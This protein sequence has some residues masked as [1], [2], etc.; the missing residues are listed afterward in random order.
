MGTEILHD[1]VA[2]ALRDQAFVFEVL[3]IER[4]RRRLLW[5]SPVHHRLGEGRL[6]GFVVAVTAITPHVDNDVL[7]EALPILHRDA[8]DMDA[9]LPDRRR[10]RGRSVPETTLATSEQYGEEREKLGLVVK[11]IWLFTTT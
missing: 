3:G 1:S 6:V 5:R 9:R 10:S 11:P 4:A 2:F 7:L 8:G